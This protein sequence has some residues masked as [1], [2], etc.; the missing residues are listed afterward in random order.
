MVI[1][2]CSTPLEFELFFFDYLHIAVICLFA[3]PTESSVLLYSG[4]SSHFK[5]ALFPI[6]GPVCFAYNDGLCL[7]ALM[8]D[9]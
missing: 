9:I 4:R 3:P 6:Y 8:S 1:P 7:R 5:R 2:F